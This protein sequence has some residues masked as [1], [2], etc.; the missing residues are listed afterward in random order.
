LWPHECRL[1]LMHVNV[2]WL[3]V[4][5]PDAEPG[6]GGGNGAESDGR[7]ADDGTSFHDLFSSA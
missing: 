1:V 4:G 7:A 5:Y 3:G 2:A 6:D